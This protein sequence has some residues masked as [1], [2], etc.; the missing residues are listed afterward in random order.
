MHLL[1]K[2]EAKYFYAKAG[3]KIILS[4][5]KAKDDFINYASNLVERN[6]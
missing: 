5:R 3:I 1:K 4:T 2:K 6:E